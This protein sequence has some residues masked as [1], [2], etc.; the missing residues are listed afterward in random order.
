MMPFGN[1]IWSIANEFDQSLQEPDMHLI[2]FLPC[3]TKKKSNSDNR[4]EFEML[5]RMKPWMQQSRIF[6]GMMC[7]GSL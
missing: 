2:L 5:M 1:Q 4:D 6:R 3:Y 7:V